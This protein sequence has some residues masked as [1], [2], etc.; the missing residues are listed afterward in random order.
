MFAS[1]EFFVIASV[2][3]DIVTQHDIDHY[4]TREEVFTAWFGLV[5]P[6]FSQKYLLLMSRYL[7]HGCSVFDVQDMAR[8]LYHVRS[9]G[10]MS[11]LMHQYRIHFT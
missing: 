9:Y 1:L 10:Y 3:T 6:V 2:A 11:A 7:I 8:S 5:V 4:T